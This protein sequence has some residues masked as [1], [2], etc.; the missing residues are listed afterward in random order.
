MT[1]TIQRA[2][3][4]GGSIMVRIPKEIVEIEGIKEGETLQ[5]DIKKLKK[6]FFGITPGLLPFNKATDRM[7]FKYE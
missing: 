3:K 7:R 6:D 1:E 2:R 4:V 5:V